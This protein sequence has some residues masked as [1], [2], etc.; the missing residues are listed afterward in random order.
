MRLT[1]FLISPNQWV[2]WSDFIRAQN[3]TC[4]K[5]VRR[6]CSA[7]LFPLQEM[8]HKRTPSLYSEVRP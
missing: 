7:N 3:K 1:G 4:P 6:A 8:A 2:V 5:E